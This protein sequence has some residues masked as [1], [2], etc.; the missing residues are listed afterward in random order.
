MY[1]VDVDT[2]FSY[3]CA[4]A[5][6]ECDGPV[7]FQ[8]YDYETV[9]IGDQC[10]FAE[11]LRSENYRN[12]D[13]NYSATVYGESGSCSSNSPLGDACDAE[14]SLME[15]GRL[16]RW[17]AVEDVRGLC[18]SGWHVPSDS[19]WMTLELHLGVPEEELNLSGGRGSNEA[20]GLKS[21]EGW[22]YGGRQLHRNGD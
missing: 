13:A 4:Q 7:S 12:G 9:L 19:D 17:D 2:A 21:V 6:G 14:W 18:P 8:G 22:A 5:F 1:A 15:Y 11:N 16:Y 10:W 3:T 20:Y